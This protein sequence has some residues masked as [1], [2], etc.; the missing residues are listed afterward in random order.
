MPIIARGN[1]TNT[2]QDSPACAKA[3]DMV[4][5]FATLIGGQDGMVEMRATNVT[6]HSTPT[7]RTESTLYASDDPGIRQMIKDARA[8]S[9]RASAVYWTL[10]PVMPSVGSGSATDKH[11]RSRKWILFDAD[12]IRPADTCSTDEEKAVAKLV[13]SDAINALTDAGFGEPIIAD[14]GNGRHALYHCDLP[15]NDVYRDFVKALLHRVG[16]LADRDG[17]RID[18]SVFNASR[19]CRLYGTLNRKGPNTPERPH[20]AS[21]II[22]IPD[23]LDI[24]TPDMLAR[25]LARPATRAVSAPAPP[26]KRKGIHAYDLGSEPIP[27]YVTKAYEEEIRELASAG[28]GERNNTLFKVSAALFE[29]VGPDKLDAA[30]VE[31]RLRQTAEQIGLKAAEI[32]RTI[33]SARDR[34]SPRDLG[35]VGANGKATRMPVVVDPLTDIKESTADPH[36]LAR[37][38]LKALHH[39]EDGI[40]LR[41]WNDNWHRWEDGR[42]IVT[43]QAEL[44]ASVAA[45]VKREFDRIAIEKNR[46]VLA[47]GTGI[48]RDV[49]LA[50]RSIATIPLSLVPEQPAWIDVEGPPPRECLSTRSGIVHLPS[51]MSESPG[52]VE[53][54]SPRFFSPNILSYP[55][56]PEAPR[57]DAWLGFLDSVWPSDPESIDT[58]Q[59]WFGYMLT[60]DT[61]HQ[62]I[63]M[64][65]GQPRSGKGTIARTI[66]AMIGEENLDSPKLSSLGT[67]FGLQPLIGK[68]AAICPEARLTGRSDSQ[69]IVETLLSISGEDH[70]SIERK[71]QTNWSGVLRTRFTLLCNE[72][73]R[74]GDYS[75]ALPSR[76][77]VLK[78]GESF[79]GREDIDLDG[80][81]GRELPSILLW[82]LAGWERL[83][84]RGKFV[85]PASGAELMAEFHELN[86]PMGLFVAERCEMEPESEVPVKRLYAAWKDWCEKNGK[87]RPGDL[88]GF[89]RSLRSFAPHLRTADRRESG[90]RYRVFVGIRL[91][92]H[93]TDF[94]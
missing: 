21:R 48:V 34:A 46:T 94:S 50:I 91:N 10:N 8:I 54:S 6:R 76:L 92:E 22:H 16:D 78:M 73:P 65:V 27:A 61:R 18:R 64:L 23:R 72:L 51:V 83:A 82:A 69:A 55:Y 37:G 87:D 59:E 77:L 32:D 7:T 5:W 3:E 42:W 89:G 43:Q 74:L 30:D 38:Y 93:P 88:Q 45:Y 15:N 12:P 79:T 41:A 24:V 1:D 28:E 81:I 58:L 2:P 9:P 62:K 68:L 35:H 67:R 47:V 26:K 70:Q 36:R 71:G 75:S 84:A 90:A 17:A 29:L 57:P 63:L 25:L 66:K 19:I 40:T 31:R 80:K 20:R 56:D 13:L 14:S 86:N 33:Q 44:T 53:P 39:H 60:H 4:R 49:V 85:Q 52:A 11:I